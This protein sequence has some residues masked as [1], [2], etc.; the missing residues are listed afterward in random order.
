MT[1]RMGDFIQPIPKGD[2][3]QISAEFNI[4]AS[5][6]KVPHKFNY[7]YPKSTVPKNLGSCN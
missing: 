5:N 4:R 2:L 7:T 1:N 6:S 3:E